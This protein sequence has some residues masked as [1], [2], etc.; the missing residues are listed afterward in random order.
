LTPDP[1]SISWKLVSSIVTTLEMLVHEPIS[2]DADAKMSTPWLKPEK[3][4][5]LSNRPGPTPKELGKRKPMRRTPCPSSMRP[6]W[7]ST[8]GNFWR[9]GIV[10]QPA[11]VTRFR[12]A[13]SAPRA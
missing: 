9:L 1:V 4:P 2:M 10:G 7:L 8:R 11:Q 13:H 12:F 3:S 5:I 6:P